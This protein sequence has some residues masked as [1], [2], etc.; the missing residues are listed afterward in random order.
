MDVYLRLAIISLQKVKSLP[1]SFL[2]ISKILLVFHVHAIFPHFYFLMR[3]PVTFM[4]QHLFLSAFFTKSTK[5]SSRSSILFFQKF[6]RPLAS[7]I[8]MFDTSF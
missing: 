2:Q 8:L 3:F 6:I 4:K 7:V 5:S 1:V